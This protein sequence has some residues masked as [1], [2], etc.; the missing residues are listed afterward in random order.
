VRV[1]TYAQVRAYARV[2][3]YAQVG[4]Y[5]RVGAYAQVGAYVRVGAYGSFKK[6]PSEFGPTLY[7]VLNLEVDGLAP[8]LVSYPHTCSGF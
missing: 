1:R 6:L 3:A 8:Q 5:A 2:G 4:S 7:V